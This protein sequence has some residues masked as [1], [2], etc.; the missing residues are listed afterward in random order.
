MGPLAIAGTIAAILISIGLVLALL[1]PVFSGKQTAT[2]TP[3]LPGVLDNPTAG[4]L[5]AQ[6]A[7]EVPVETP[8]PDPTPSTEPTTAPP[9]APPAA[10]NAAIENAVV[11]LVNAARRKTK[12]APVRVNAQLRDAAR[13]HSADMAAGGFLSHKGSDGSSADDRMQEAGFDDPLSENVAKGFTSAQ[14]VVKAWLNSRNDRKGIEDCD[15]GSIGVGVVVSDD[16]TPYWTQDL[17]E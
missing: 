17:G 15:A 4:A 9:S 12:C 16:G 3:H 2:T 10:G 1:S 11:S 5:P 13:R 6:P 7:P 14:G 8:S